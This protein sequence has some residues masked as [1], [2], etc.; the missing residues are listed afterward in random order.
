MD[1]NNLHRRL[2]QIAFY[3]SE[4]SNDLRTLQS[5]RAIESQEEIELDIDNLNSFTP[6]RHR[7]F[8]LKAQGPGPLGP[9]NLE[10]MILSNETDFNKR[11]A[12]S[13]PKV[14]NFTA[15]ERYTLNKLARDDKFV[16]KPSD[17]GGAVVLWGRE[18][19]LREGYKQLSDLTS[20]KRM[21]EDL[22]EKHRIEVQK[23]VEDMYQ[24]GDIDETVKKYL[25][26]I[27][28]KTPNLYLLP[29]IHK[30]IKPTPGRPVVSANGCPTEKIS[31]LVDH[32]LNPGCKDI[33]SFVKDTTHFLNLM[34][35]LGAIPEESWLV[36]L[37][38][39]ALYPNIPIKEGL[40]AAAEALQI[41]RPDLGVNQAT[42]I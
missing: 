29:K 20:Y 23:V 25:T 17:K 37:D 32:F 5:Q 41:E 6:F 38:V 9:P 18:D 19:Y 24:E 22:T 11:P 4:E 16:I 42:E 3:D 30:Q 27:K 26:D 10:A 34:G 12:Y 1:L 28:S 15:S 39:T 21:E 36:T 14:R 2:R 8:K 40:E 13:P 7:K 31:Q 35:G 33:R